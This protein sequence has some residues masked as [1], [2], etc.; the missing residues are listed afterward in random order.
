MNNNNNLI[1]RF[2]VTSRR[3]EESACPAPT[4]KPARPLCGA[5]TR[6]ESRCVTRADSTQNYT[7]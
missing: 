5:E 1:S 2:S 6:R 7:G 4:V 3:P